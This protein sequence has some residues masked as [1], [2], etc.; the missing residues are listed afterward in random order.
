MP[1]IDPVDVGERRAFRAPGDDRVDRIGLALEL[2]LDSAVEGVAD[3]P[4][5]AERPCPLDARRSEEDALNP[6]PNLDVDPS[7]TAIVPSATA[8]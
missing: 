7:H 3:P 8:D 6:S 2:R 4:A 1:D 5:D